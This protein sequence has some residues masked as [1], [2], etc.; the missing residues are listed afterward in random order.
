MNH[1][2]SRPRRTRAPSPRGFT[3]IE[4]MIA[5]AMALA[6]TTAAL[7]ILL[8][9]IETQRDGAIRASLERDAQLTMD[10]IGYDLRYAGVGI[11]RGYQIQDDGDYVD[12][13]GDTNIIPDE[14]GD[15][16]RPIIR[17]GLADYLAFLGDLPYPNADLNGVVGITTFKDSNGHRFGV[18]SE[19]SPC[20]PSSN[21]GTSGNYWCDS[22]AASMIFQ[23]GDY[24]IGTACTSS[25][26]SQPTCPWGMNKWQDDDTSEVNIILGTVTG[27][28][29]RRHWDDDDRLISALDRAMLHMEHWEPTGVGGGDDVPEEFFRSEI[30]G[31]GFASIPDRVFYSLENPDRSRPCASPGPCALR[32]RQCWGWGDST[33]SSDSGFPGIQASAIDSSASPAD[34]TTD[35]DNAD[36]SHWETVIDDLESFTFRYYD[37]RGNELTP[38]GSGLSAADSA[39]ARVVEVDLTIS[40]TATGSGKT[41][42][43]TLTRRFFMENAGGLVTGG[44]GSADIRTPNANGG[45]W[46]TGV[47][48]N[49]PPN[50]CTPQ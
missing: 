2:T 8:S 37:A 4:V 48:A 17:I 10:V 35:P 6:I 30:F 11:P 44:Q 47:D 20:T 25:D 3:L 15:Q 41:F 24:G 7:G 16:L 34:C 22:T 46:D 28:W 39:K 50:E 33:R 36:G 45:C 21:G 29:L 43:H 31:G 19:L 32:R 38:A 26:D 12:W 40:R 23:S 13:D 5:M 42:S 18:S 14:A 9:V 27:A 1:T 49:A